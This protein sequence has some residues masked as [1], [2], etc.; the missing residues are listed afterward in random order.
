MA[1]PS[2]LAEKTASRCWQVYRYGVRIGH[3]GE[4]FPKPNDTALGEPAFIAYTST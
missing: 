1:L 2:R 4:A 3:L